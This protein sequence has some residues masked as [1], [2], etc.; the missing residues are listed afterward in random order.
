MKYIIKKAIIT[1]LFVFGFSLNFFAQEAFSEFEKDKQ[2]NNVIVNKKMFEMMS[3][4]KVNQSS[5]EDKAYFNLIK[6]LDNLR[7][8]HTKNDAS[9]S[10]MTTAVADYAS[11]KGLKQF[12]S[13]NKNGAEVTI[14]INK[15]G[16][17]TNVNEL[18]MLNQ[19]SSKGENSIMYLQGSFSINEISALTNKMNLPV[20]DSFK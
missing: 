8:F 16:S 5:E 13:S 19:D 9:K 17:A 10:K 4:V 20:G 6:K 14:Y 3:N 15:D 7:V 18:V 12:S 2:V 11:K 1:L